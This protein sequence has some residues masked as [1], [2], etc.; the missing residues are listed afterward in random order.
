MRRACR[1]DATVPRPAVRGARTLPGRTASGYPAGVH[2][3]WPTRVRVVL[4]LVNLS[5][6]LGLLVA[7]L[8]GARIRRGER[9]LL[10][11]EGYRPAF[12]VAG[13]FTIGDVVTTPHTVEEVSRLQPDVLAHEERHAWQWALT[14]WRFLPLY[15]AASAWSWVRTGDPAV[16]NVF[17]RDAGLHSG[18]YLPPDAPVPHWTGRGLSAR[19]GGA[20]SGSR[21]GAGEGGAGA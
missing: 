8:G 10:L 7:R 5:T 16:L 21:G 9:G 14:G 1:R 19:R 17:E 4:N 18:G 3:R 12:P 11:A 13:A 15:G 20:R 2:R 6:P